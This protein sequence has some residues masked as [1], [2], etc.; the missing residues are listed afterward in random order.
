MKSAYGL[1]VP[2]DL[3]EV[4]TPSRAAVIIYD[5]QVGVV[6]QIREGGTVLDRCRELLEAAR[7][8]GYRVFFTRHMF[9][10][11]RAAGIGQLRRAMVWQ[12]KTD[13]LETKPFFLQGSPPWEI[14][15]EL[16][17]RE[18]ETVIDKITMSGFEGTFLSLAMRD[19]QLSSF[20]IAGIA[21][22]VGIEPTIRHGLDLNYIP[23][24]VRDA[25]GSKTAE[26]KA[27]SLATLAETGE[28][29]ATDTP[30]VVAVMGA[31]RKG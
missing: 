19:A 20:L 23:I 6:S 22:E 9:L 31:G 30:E 25:C 2:E 26:K 17:P 18:N 8:G 29:L 7:S 27:H 3:K 11:N 15:P 14:V 28:V 10:P 5:M 4:C 16:S 24:L 1:V 21:L 12:R 13:P